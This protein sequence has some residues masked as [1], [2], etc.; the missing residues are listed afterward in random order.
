MAGTI[1]RQ[2]VIGSNELKA[3][4]KAMRWDEAKALGT[5]VLLW[6]GSQNRKM[7]RAPAELI[8]EW[9]RVPE[10]QREKIVDVLVSEK[11]GFIRHVRGRLGLFE[12]V[13]NKKQVK[14][15]KQLSA[16]RNAGGK[17]TREKFSSTKQEIS[18]SRAENGSSRAKSAKQNPEQD[19]I[20]DAEVKL[21]P[22]PRTSPPFPAPPCTSIP[23]TSLPSTE[24]AVPAHDPNQESFA[25]G[26]SGAGAPEDVSSPMA[27]AVIKLD[28]AGKLDEEQ[29]NHFAGIF[30]EGRMRKI[31]EVGR[32]ML[33]GL[34]MQHA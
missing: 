2:E 9:C 30:G 10:K 21:D 19:H 20:L 12:I 3:L 17:T 8:A 34:E 25:L 16:L 29:F 33:G 22:I 24:P 32:A 15:L 6:N 1:V 13:G 26:G 23:R 27:Q 7:T 14:K 5:L 4:M 18:S 11:C 28:R 31:I